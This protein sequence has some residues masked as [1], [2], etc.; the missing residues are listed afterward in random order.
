MGYAINGYLSIFLIGI[1]GQAHSQARYAILKVFLDAGLAS[2]SVTDSGDDL[3][4]RVD[5]SKIYTT[6]VGAVN[7]F[8]T[9]LQVLKATGDSEAGI[10]WYKEIT[11]VSEEWLTYRDIVIKRK[12]PRKVF[13]QVIANFNLF[14]KL[15]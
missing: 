5:R 9:K 12:Q 2:I 6:G 11:N 15:I 7:K 4:V 3:I 10:S 14:F 1:L 13:I 8:L